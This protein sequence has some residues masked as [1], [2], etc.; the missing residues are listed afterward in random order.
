MVAV[1]GLRTDDWT[2]RRPGDEPIVWRAPDLSLPSVWIRLL[3]VWYRFR[4]YMEVTTFLLGEPQLLPVLFEAYW[5][6]ARCFDP[7]PQVVLEVAQDPDDDPDAP[8]QLLILI[9]TNLNAP[10]AL[11]R[12]DALDRSWWLDVPWEFRQHLV[13]DVEYV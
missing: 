12:L 7:R 8:P 1:L 10:E 4:N 2:I 3:E 6:I 13:L 5:H 11:S 9:Q